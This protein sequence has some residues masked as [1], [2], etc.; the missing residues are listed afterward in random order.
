VNAVRLLLLIELRDLALTHH[1]S[2]H[3]GAHNDT[4]A[5][6][7]LP[8]HLQAG[9]HEGFLDG[10]QAKLRIPVHAFPLGAIQVLA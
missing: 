8:V 2:A 6:G 5:I 1:H 3:A 7:V 10:H 4:Q 9:I